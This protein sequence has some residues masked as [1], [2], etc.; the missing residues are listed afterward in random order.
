MKNNTLSY[1]FFNADHESDSRNWNESDKVLFFTFMK[2]LKL[3]MISVLVDHINIGLDN[4]WLVNRSS[5][6][7]DT[8]KLIVLL[9]FVLK[10]S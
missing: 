5:M 10:G 8:V 1:L 4:P 9:Y 3:T 7:I 6:K 2:N